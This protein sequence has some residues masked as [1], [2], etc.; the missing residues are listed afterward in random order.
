[1]TLTPG[2]ANVAFC[3]HY[4]MRET[5]QTASSFAHSIAFG[6]YDLTAAKTQWG[7]P[8]NRIEVDFLNDGLCSISAFGLGKVSPDLSVPA[9]TPTRMTGTI[10]IV[11]LHNRCE[12]TLDDKRIFYGPAIA[13][14]SKRRYGLFMTGVGVSGPVNPPVFEQLDD[15][16]SGK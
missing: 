1:M 13:D 15:P 9:V 12:V 14:E 8:T 16:R 7:N 2:F 11:I 10:R 5:D 6:L 4:N 3:A